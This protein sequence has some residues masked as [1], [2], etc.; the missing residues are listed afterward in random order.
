[1]YYVVNLS[2]IISF[3]K[4]AISKIPLD[5]ADIEK[6]FEDNHHRYINNANAYQPGIGERFAYAVVQLPNGN[7]VTYGSRIKNTRDSDGNIKSTIVFSWYDFNFAKFI[8]QV[9]LE[10]SRIVVDLWLQEASS[11]IVLKD[12]CAEKFYYFY[13]MGHQLTEINTSYFLIPEDVE[14]WTDDYKREDG[15]G[16]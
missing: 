2:Q 16:F 10:M 4:K 7:W 13:N 9:K 8:S 1:M 5:Y 6:D 14:P 11:C 15:P 3:N 12:S